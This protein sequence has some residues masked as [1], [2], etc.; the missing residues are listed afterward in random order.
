MH[1][2][3]SIT[4]RVYGVL[5]ADDVQSTIAGLTTSHSTDQ[6]AVIELL[7]SLLTKMKQGEQ[8]G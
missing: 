3:L 8:A 5:S 4:D 1:A 7:E 6:Q 2:D